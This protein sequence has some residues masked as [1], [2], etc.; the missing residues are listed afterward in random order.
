MIEVSD[1]APHYF[2][3]KESNAHNSVQHHDD[4]DIGEQNVKSSSD[5]AF[6]SFNNG[7][8]SSIPAFFRKRK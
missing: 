7:S 8:G 6:A 5:D 2:S 1:S 3:E 4:M